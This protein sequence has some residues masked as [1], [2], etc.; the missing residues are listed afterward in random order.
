MLMM[1]KPKDLEFEPLQPC[2]QK[3]CYLLPW[4]TEFPVYYF[5]HI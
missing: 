4:Y 3:M 1:K 5:P 2:T